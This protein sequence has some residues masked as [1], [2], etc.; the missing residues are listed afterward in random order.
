MNRKVK[1]KK[2]NHNTQLNCLIIVLHR[3]QFRRPKDISAFNG[4]V[5]MILT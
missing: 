5:D 2:R 1:R 4:I 3:V